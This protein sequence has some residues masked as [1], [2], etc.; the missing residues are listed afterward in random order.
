MQTGATAATVGA[1]HCPWGP[2]QSAN[3]GRFLY[4]GSCRGNPGKL[5]VLWGKQKRT[6]RAPR[7]PCPPWLYAKATRR[8]KK[9]GPRRQESCT[10]LP[11][12]DLSS[13]TPSP[14]TQPGRSQP[15][16]HKSLASCTP[17]QRTTHRG[18]G[19]ANRVEL[20][21]PE[22][23]REV[24]CQPANSRL[25]TSAAH[26][27]EPGQR[28]SAPQGAW[29]SQPCTADSVMAQEKDRDGQRQGK[30][31][32]AQVGQES[33]GPRRLPAA[34]R[35]PRTRSEGPHPAPDPTPTFPAEVRSSSQGER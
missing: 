19:G 5:M 4:K 9:V 2:E 15:P 10:D 20:C 30:T 24:P 35:C 1:G 23:E 13:L 31:T 26:P 14:H 3:T 32:W 21:S 27:R 33:A 28:G 6:G 25:G 7:A 22:D 17:L 29:T 18:P 34:A 16:P 8:L 11:R 12:N